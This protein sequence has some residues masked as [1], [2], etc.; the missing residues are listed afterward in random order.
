MDRLIK[1]DMKRLLIL[2]TADTSFAKC[3]GEWPKT[4]S[5]GESWLISLLQLQVR[6]ER[7]FLTTFIGI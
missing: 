1:R 6:Q 2:R 5:V 4:A 7:L 3:T